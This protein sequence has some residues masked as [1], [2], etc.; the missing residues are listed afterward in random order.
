[1]PPKISIIVPNW[2]GREFLARCIGGLL[3]SAEESGAPFELLLMDDASTDG[4]GR[5][6]AGMFPQ[7]RLVEQPENRGFGYTVNHGASI[8]SGDILMLVN[9]DLVPRAGF[10]ENLCRHFEGRDDLFGVS[11]KTVDWEAGSP[12]H[13]NMS[14]EFSGGSFHLKWSDETLPAPTMFM[15]GGSCA[16]RRDLFL[17][18]GGLCDLYAPAYWEDYDLSYQALK[19]GYINLY[20]P[21]AV[22]SHL[23]QGS[24]IRAY[25]E[26]R[27]QY[28]KLR[29]RLLF[30]ALN[31]TDPDLEKAFWSSVPAFVR[32]GREARFQTRLKVFSFLWKHRATIRHE[33]RR[34]AQY[35]AVSDAELLKQFAGIG[36]LC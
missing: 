28:F 11:G 23:G 21:G 5:D 16:V 3:Q 33:R 1:M 31:L 24:M 36:T 17:R 18:F 34:R 12:N 2:N 22:G 32:S 7:V 25:G 8:A 10:V 29:N 30:H 27:V 14:A 9:N 35:L 19:A 15:Q 26:E 6:V 20:D 13:V 4:S